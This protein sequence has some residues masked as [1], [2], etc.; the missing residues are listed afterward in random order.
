MSLSDQNFSI[1]ADGVIADHTLPNTLFQSIEDYQEF[2]DERRAYHAAASDFELAVSR[3][4]LN[5]AYAAYRQAGLN[6]SRRRLRQYAVEDLRE[7]LEAI[8][9]GYFTEAEIAWQTRN[10]R[11]RIATLYCRE[12]H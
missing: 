7:K 10:P 1:L 4:G 9:N 2:A 12:V 3:Q 5:H 8:G 6:V 11:K